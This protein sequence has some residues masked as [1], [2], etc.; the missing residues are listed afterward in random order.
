MRIIVISLLQCMHSQQPRQFNAL[1]LLNLQALRRA[2]VKIVPKHC[3]KK[4]A[5]TTSCF[6]LLLSSGLIMLLMSCRNWSTH[7]TCSAE[8]AFTASLPFSQ[9]LA[10]WQPL[11]GLT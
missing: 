5:E 3:S 2:H 8:A 9:A 6:T 10:P 7:A 11:R 4:A 1:T